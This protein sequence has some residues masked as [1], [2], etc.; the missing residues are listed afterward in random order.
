MTPTI[1]V[2]GIRLETIGAY[3]EVSWE[4]DAD[5]GCG[6]IQ[7]SM[8]LPATFA[9]PLL[10]T[11]RVVKLHA[12]ARSLC[13]GVLSEPDI[14]TDDTGATWTFTTKAP[15]A[16]KVLCLDGSG[17]TSAVPDTAIDAAI[18]RGLKWSRPA[19]LSST[20]FVEDA[21][22]GDQTDALNYLGDLL[23]AWSVSVSKRWGVD[24]DL[25]VYAAADP[26]T[27]AYHLTPG[28]GR[29]GLADD[30]YASAVFVRYLNASGQYATASADND[31]TGDQYGIAEY[32]L[33]ATS[34]GVLTS[35]KAAGLAAGALKKGK[36]RLGWTAGITPNPWQLT[37]P[38]GTPVPWWL[39]KAQQM[40]RMH[41]VLNDQG[42]PLPYVD[43]VIG[44]TTHAGGVLTIEPVGLAART[45]TS[46]LAQ[47]IGLAS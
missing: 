2:D 20:A 22:T 19:S 40:V 39:P 16:A 45:L 6:P 17:N 15:S 10:T 35:T 13:A 29:F 30:D 46:V 21:A 28:A 47:A 27:P 7:W 34:M 37:T 36:A 42:Q 12:G 3:G 44:K 24:A 11:G 32:G 4:T 8:Q 31:V 14:N 25:N 33:D 1:T 9:H 26:T 43:F 38:G 18:A 5:G 41:G 23:D